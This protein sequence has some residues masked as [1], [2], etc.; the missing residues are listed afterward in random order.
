V[1][2]A[3]KV[4]REQKLDGAPALAVASPPAPALQSAS[5][6]PRWRRL[7]LLVVVPALVVAGAVYLYLQGGRFVDTENAYVKADKAIIT[8]EV[9]GRIIEVAVRD[10]DP[11]A[12][13]DVLFRID[14]APYQI[15]L[16]RA[17]AALAQTTTALEALVVDYRQALA[18][19][20]LRESNLAFARAN[21]ARIE[22][23]MARRLAAVSDL[24]AV[25]HELDTAAQQVEVARQQAARVLVDLGGDVDAP[26]TAHARYRQALA[27]RDQAALDLVHA[28]VVAPFAGVV[29]QKPEP[30]TYIERGRSVMALVADRHMWVEAN[31]KE[32]DLTHIEPG[33]SADIEI[34]TYPGYRFH[35][36]VQSISEAT[37]AEFALLPPQNATGNWVKVVQRVPVRVELADAQRAAPRLRAGMSATVTIDTG[38]RRRVT[39]LIPGRG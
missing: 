11:V 10:N 30:G 24:D 7:L 36:V 34:D 15:A 12:A 3:L 39:E 28:T 27:D 37:G 33:Q 31:F 19:V 13:G 9:S 35:G 25:Q 38:H 16:Q 32:T 17:E 14:P 26:L 29:S 23:L 22:G 1:S 20:E 18:E 4:N 8:A 21:H 5:A 6:P 2:E